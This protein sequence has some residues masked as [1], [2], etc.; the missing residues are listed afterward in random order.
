MRFIRILLYVSCMR[1]SI[2]AAN[3]CRNTSDRIA[4]PEQIRRAG[5]LPLL[6]TKNERFQHDLIRDKVS[7]AAGFTVVRIPAVDVLHNSAVVMDR[8][9]R[10]A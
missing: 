9:K 6:I 10:L 2:E 8:L 3:E 5:N 7:E 4:L 1:A